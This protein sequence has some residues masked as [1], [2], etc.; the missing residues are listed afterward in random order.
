MRENATI[1]RVM[2]RARS[3][4]ALP[5]RPEEFSTVAFIFSVE[6]TDD[7]EDDVIEDASVCAAVEDNRISIISMS[8]HGVVF[9]EN[10]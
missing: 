2:P 8:E 10:E 1:T 4:I 5:E 9:N 6:V 3:T 7:D